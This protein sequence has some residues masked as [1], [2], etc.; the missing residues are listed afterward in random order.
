ERLL[1]QKVN[2]IIGAAATGMYL[3]I[4]DKVKSAQKVQC[5]GSNSA[6]TFT[7]YNDDGF[8]F[9]TAPSDV[10]QGPILADTITGDGHDTVAITYR[11][12]DYGKGL[13]EATKAAL[14]NVGATVPVMEAYE[15]NTTNFNATVSKIDRKS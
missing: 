12:D 15:P 11:G 1:H 2:S 9:R 7:D 6:P 13:A 3:A 8:Y 10:L 4:L 5:S 14:E